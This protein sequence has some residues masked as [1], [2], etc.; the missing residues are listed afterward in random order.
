MVGAHGAV[1]AGIVLN[2]VLGLVMVL[3]A[4]RTLASW[5]W[6]AA[7]A[8]P[9]WCWPASSGVAGLESRPDVVRGRHVRAPVPALRR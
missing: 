8:R 3:A 5:Q 9:S 4:R 6:L 2:L 1:K 7:L